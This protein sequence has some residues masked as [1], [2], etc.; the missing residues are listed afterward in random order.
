MDCDMNGG[1]AGNSMSRGLEE[2]PIW[3]LTS[4]G[5]PVVPRRL[6]MLLKGKVLLLLL[7]VRRRHVLLR[8]VHRLRVLLHVTGRRASHGILPPDPH[9][10][11]AI[12]PPCFFIEPVVEPI[13][14]ISTFGAPGLVL[15][16][17]DFRFEGRNNHSL[18]TGSGICDSTEHM[19]DIRLAAAF[20]NIDD[21][22]CLAFFGRQLSGSAGGIRIDG[23]HHFLFFIIV[24]FLTATV[25]RRR[26]WVI[27]NLIN[28]SEPIHTNPLRRAQS[29]I[30]AAA[31]LHHRQQ[32]LLR[33]EVVLPQELE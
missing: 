26:G 2:I 28:K 21:C 6:H 24:I 19:A 33:E 29:S 1:G 25:R 3:I 8:W 31:P 14:R 20:G 12:P 5:R 13:A 7:N 10:L 15:E 9:L 32:N 16:I 18:L 23:Y 22:G 30:F 17:V 4:W 27:L 11:F